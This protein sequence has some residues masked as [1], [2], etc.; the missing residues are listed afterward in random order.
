VAFWS[1]EVPVASPTTPIDQVVQVVVAPES[2]SLDPNQH[3][4]FAAYGRTTGG[5]SSVVAVTWTAT[6]GSIASDGM[7]AADT[8][9][10]DFLVTG[11]NA[12]LKLSASSRV[13]IRPRPVASVS[14]T[15]ASVSGTPGQTFQLAAAPRDAGGNLL[16][17]RRRE[18]QHGCG[19]RGSGL[20]MN[21]AA[22]RQPSQRRAKARADGRDCDAD[23]GEVASA[24]VRP[25]A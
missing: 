25:P 16:S 13:R 3:M 1:C 19:E 17:G 6:G 15:P 7:F 22:G 9:A 21:V 4:K 20:V 8:A 10:G 5:D 23:V 18:Q 24:A 11:T 2:I 14:V 12:T